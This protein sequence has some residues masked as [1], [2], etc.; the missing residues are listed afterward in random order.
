MVLT[1]DSGR[2]ADDATWLPF[3]PIFGMKSP[4]YKISSQA[5]PNVLEPSGVV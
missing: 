1:L 3:S 5:K 4:N 2:Y